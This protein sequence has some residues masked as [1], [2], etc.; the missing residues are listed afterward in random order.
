MV[1]RQFWDKI[2]SGLCKKLRQGTHVADFGKISARADPK[3]PA[4]DP[5]MQG[6]LAGSI[7]PT[8]YLLVAR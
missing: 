1:T 2:I 8:R 4:N 6:S 7:R 3:G 5:Y